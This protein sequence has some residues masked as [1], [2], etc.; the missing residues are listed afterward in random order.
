MKKRKQRIQK[1]NSRKFGLCIV[2]LTL[3]MFY[4]TTTTVMAYENG[5]GFGENS[6]ENLS[7]YT[8]N[9]DGIQGLKATSSQADKAVSEFDVSKNKAT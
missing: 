4:L 3:S 7:L 8:Y 6:L 2:S 5:L 1:F 9:S